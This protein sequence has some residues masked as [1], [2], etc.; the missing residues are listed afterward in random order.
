MK[1]FLAIYLGSPSDAVMKNWQSLDSETRKEKEKAG[2]KGWKDWINNNSSIIDAGS[3]IGKTKRIDSNGISD[4]K[5]L[6]CGYTIVEAESQEAA[7]KL[8]INHP[9]FS[10]FP[11]DSVEIMECLPIPE[12]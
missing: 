10:V 2:I 8:F 3:P 5:N 11:G 12:M 9:H 7:A 1:K 4:T 6:I